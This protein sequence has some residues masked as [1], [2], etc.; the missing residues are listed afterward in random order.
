MSW[1]LV[2]FIPGL[3]MLA[4]F[5][6]ER[7]EAGLRHDTFSAADVA[8]FLDKAE[9][10]DVDALARNGMDSALHGLA[11][12]RGEVDSATGGLSTVTPASGLPTRE[13]FHGRLN[14]EFQQT[15]HA[16]PV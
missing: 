12:R 2:A 6:L 5:G 13:Y 9:A 14:N 10:G 11:Q 3:L 4:T 16:N 15:R 7:V 1:L 8:E